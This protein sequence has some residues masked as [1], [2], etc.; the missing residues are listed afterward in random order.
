MVARPVVALVGAFGEG[1]G[2]VGDYLERRGFEVRA[3][4]S[5]W[6]AEALLTAPGL[7]VAV[8]EV[9][10]DAGSG[11]ALLRRFGRAK[12][13][14]SSSS[15]ANGPTSSKRFWRSSSA[16][17]TVVGKSV[18]AREL[19]ARVSRPGRP[20]RQG[21]R[22][23]RRPGKRDRRPQGG[24][25]HAPQRRGGDAVSWPSRA[26]PAVSGKSRQG[27]DARRHHGRR[28]RPRTPTRSTGRSIRASSGCG[29]SS[30]PSGSSRYA[31]RVTGSTRRA[32]Q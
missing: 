23:A 24:A 1:E 5:V 21:R 22:R 12:A 15:S 11:I 10:G 30:I 16:P 17:P 6:E 26:A 27:A 2:S 19:A 28:A 31:V 13:G 29:A 8:V 25:G 14:R 4:R 7:D 20:P 32:T 3:A 18:S 9:D